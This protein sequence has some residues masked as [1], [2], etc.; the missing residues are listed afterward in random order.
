MVEDIKRVRID[1]PTTT[2]RSAVASVT[3]TSTV[4]PVSTDLTYEWLVN[5]V[6]TGTSDALTIDNNLIS[7]GINV[8]E[9]NVT[10]DQTS[11][12][13]TETHYVYG[14]NSCICPSQ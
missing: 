1:G 12:T 4:E 8:I 10:H 2:N 9:C 14:M 3:F 6:P 13:I 7:E 11:T 5:S